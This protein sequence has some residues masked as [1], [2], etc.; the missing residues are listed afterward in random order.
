[1]GHFQEALLRPLDTQPDLPGRQVLDENLWQWKDQVYQGLNFGSQGLRRKRLLSSRSHEHSS[2]CYGKLQFSLDVA[3]HR[4]LFQEW[5]ST[6]YDSRREWIS[7]TDIFHDGTWVWENLGKPLDFSNWAPG[8]P[9]NW[10]GLQHCAAIKLWEEN[11]KWDDIG[12][13]AD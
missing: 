3:Q 13:E 10:G 5:N 12:C 1:M 9:N 8:E 2:S 4:H 6:W 7:L 11:G